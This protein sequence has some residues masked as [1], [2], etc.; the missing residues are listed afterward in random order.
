MPDFYTFKWLGFS[1]QGH[2][3]IENIYADFIGKVA[4]MWNMDVAK[5]DQVAQGRIWTGAQAEQHKLVDRLGTFSDAINEARRRVAS[6]EG[7]SE[8][9]AKELPI[10]YVG[11]KRSPVEKII[12]KF[13]GHLGISEDDN[14]THSQWQ[15]LSNL[16]GSDALAL[17]SLGQELMWLQELIEKKQAFGTAAHCLCQIAP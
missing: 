9:N 17:N 5:V 1:G 16:S 7:Q 15:I 2:S 11:P 13:M 12:Q 8:A 10:R 6:L 3:S 4:K 14:A